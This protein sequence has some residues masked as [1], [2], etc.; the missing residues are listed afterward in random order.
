MPEAGDGHVIDKRATAYQQIRI[1]DPFDAGSAKSRSGQVI[2]PLSHN[3]LL[4][5]TLP[6]AGVPKNLLWRIFGVAKRGLLSVDQPRIGVIGAG[7]HAKA[8]IYPAARLAGAL[9]A[10]VCARHL[11][12]AQATAGE[13]GVDHAYASPAEMLRRE[14]LDAVF[15]IAPEKEQAGVVREV[16]RA[17]LPVFAEKPVGLDEHEADEIA[18]LAARTGK[19]VM[20]GFMKRF[21]PA[22]MH[23]KQFMHEPGFGDPL[24]FHGMFAIG[25]RPGWDDAW[26]IKTGGI[27]YVDLCRYLFGE[28]T[29]VRG[30]G[31]THQIQVD[32]CF[33]LRFAHGEI[34]GLFFAGVP[35]WTRHHEELTVTGTHGFARVENLL[36]V[37]A[38]LD[39]PASGDRPRWQMIDEE[40]R[41]FTPV[42]T[43]AS[44]RLKDLYLNGY[45][46]EITHFLECLRSGT[47]PQ[48]SAADNVKTMGLCDR[49]LRAIR[50]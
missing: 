44:G 20:V 27:H 9:I 11:D 4:R 34:G 24:S 46:G 10:A 23:L 40:D 33:T 30:F 22:Y 18:D 28:V 19:P 50:S 36:R 47:E 16:L 38:H 6:C 14:R 41:V 17:G 37:A 25:S 7:R 2:I 49:I 29:E 3:F 13:F 5:G 39:R 15:V 12:R 35:A 43:S 8:N 32:Q 45:V 26:F 1:L 42:H 48:P 21:A 31:N